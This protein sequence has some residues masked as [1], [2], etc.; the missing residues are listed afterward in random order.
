MTLF[1]EGYLAH[2]KGEPIDSNPY[3]K[4]EQP[5]SHQKWNE[6]WKARQRRMIEKAR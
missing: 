1:E 3:D 2:S 6:G 5:H 4:L